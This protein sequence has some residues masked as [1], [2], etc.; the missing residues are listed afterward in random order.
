M[1]STTILIKNWKEVYDI[2]LE[3]WIYRGHKNSKWPLETSLVREC[4]RVKGERNQLINTEHWMLREFRRR[5]YHYIDHLPA[6][7]DYIG[8]ITVMQHHGAV[9]R[10]LDFTFSFYVACYFAI[11]GSETDACVWAISDNWLRD[12]GCNYAMKSGFDTPDLQLR[13]DE[14][15]Y[16]YTSANRFLNETYKKHK[17]TSGAIDYLPTI[18]MVEPLIQIRR[19]A[20]Q[21][22]V[23]L[24]PT[25]I[26]LSFEK[27]L[28]AMHK[29]DPYQKNNSD[30][31][32]T[33]ISQIRKIILPQSIHD[34]AMMHLRTMNISAETL[35]PGIEGFAR[36]ITESHLP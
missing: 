19:I 33:P 35:F 32:R 3:G 26:S 17:A 7:D 34:E 36:S 10:L 13:D 31:Y 9:S 16:I 30:F 18:L 21:Q 20:V 5:A 15:D 29:Y 24:M 22:G 25:D 12:C 8:W 4:D 23:F 1:N 14:L 11:S 2:E 27:N 6:N 28:A